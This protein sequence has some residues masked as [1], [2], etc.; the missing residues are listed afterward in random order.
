M[1][2]AHCAR[3]ANQASKM[4]GKSF[5]CQGQRAY[6]ALSGNMKLVNYIGLLVL[7]CAAVS[8]LQ[9]QVT[10]NSN[11][12]ET[13]FRA[14]T[15]L[16]QV[17]V[18]VTDGSGN[19]VKDLTDKDFTILEDGKEQKVAMF[20][21]HEV[22]GALA[23]KPS[24]PAL[25]T[26]VAT[27]RPEYRAPEGTPVVLVFDGLNTAVENQM[28]VRQQMLKYLADHFDPNQKIAVFALGNEL[29]VLQDFTSDPRILARAI[30]K[31]RSQAAA[32]GRQGGSEPM[33][34]ATFAGANIPSRGTGSSDAGN[35][36]EP[37]PSLSLAN[38][39]GAL[40]RFEK[41]VEANQLE[42]RI[43]TSMD[44]LSAL[45]RYLAGFPGRK[46]VIW[47]SGSFPLNLTLL[48]RQDIS[49]YRSYAG[50][51][52]ETTNLLN[53][54][55]VAIY[56][57][58]ARGLFGNSVSDPSQSGRDSSGRMKLTVSEEMRANSKEIF[59]RFDKEDSLAKVA[60]ET[61]GRVYSN[62]N[63]IGR[64]VSASIQD[65][66][67]YYV[68]GYYPARKQWDGT[69]RTIKVKA[70]RAG[71]SL[72]HRRG[73]YASDPENWRKE[74][75]NDM[76]L[77]LGRGGVVSTGVL[78]YARAVPPSQSADAKVE[79]LVDAHTITFETGTENQ[80]YCNLEFQVQA[81]GSE[82]KLVRAEVQEAEA[83]LKPQTYDRIRQS[84][85]PM[86]VTVKLGE[87]DYT[88]R[89]GV[90]DNRTGLFGTTELPMSIH[91]Q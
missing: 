60:Q 59:E 80:H 63:D 20:S 15:R 13:V 26:N 68:L 32:A 19:P 10:Q 29:A 87:G 2:D 30:E 52:R 49:V 33:Q 81:F 43:A 47:F 72:R 24:L 34:T 73:Y 89:V 50:R 18:V 91:R 22:G 17:D 67:S 46:S 38:I 41:E 86:P 45:A 35:S 1:D 74:S 23:K 8:V 44:A 31:Y 11:D 64:A 5:A 21:F 54:A 40:A 9:G 12:S 37:N 79:F 62:T 85:L 14:T 75:A 83:P 36:P 4:P 71:L 25:P 90:R 88:L 51:I 3:S 28:Y 84:G 6:Y 82:G 48:D 66:S 65:G 53:D 57:V 56:A 77:A 58:D 42:A 27:N 16:V 78:F 55:H 7:S 39:A 70:D 69:F 76:K 61:G